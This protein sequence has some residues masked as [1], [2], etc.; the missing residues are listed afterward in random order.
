MSDKKI[1]ELNEATTI[2]GD[3]LFVVDSGIETFKMKADNAGVQLSKLQNVYKAKKTASYVIVSDDAA[4]VVLI[5]SNS[6]AFDLTLPSPS[7]NV[8]KIFRIKDVGNYLSTNQVTLKRFLTEKINGYAA[9]YLLQADEG[10]WQ[11]TSDGTDWI[12]L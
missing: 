9:D 3:A 10:F 5:D 7:L 8:G 1:T 4:K 12:I 6:S 2:T 11:L